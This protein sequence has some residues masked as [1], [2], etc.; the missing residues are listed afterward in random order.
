M[1]LFSSLTGILLSLILLV[2][3]VRKYTSTIYLGVFF[4]LVSL[5]GLVVYAQLYSGSVYLVSIF[6]YNINF[7]CYLIGPML[8]WYIRS[9]LTDHSGL[10]KRDLWHIVPMLLVLAATL[11][12]LLTSYAEK[13]EIA[14]KIVED[15]NF[16]RTYKASFIFEIAPVWVIYITRPLHIIVYALW[17][18][19]I[20]GRYLKRRRELLVLSRQYFMVRWIPFLLVFLVLGVVCHVLVLTEAFVHNGSNIM[21]SLHALQILALTGL[22]GLLVSPFFFPRILYGLPQLPEAMMVMKPVNGS[23]VENILKEPEPTPEARPTPHYEKYYMS[24]IEQKTET[25]MKDLQPFLESDFNMMQLS[26]LIKVPAH[27]IA[28]YFREVKRQSFNEYRNEWR[29]NYAKDLIRE[30]KAAQLTLEAIGFSSG[31]SSRNAFFTAFKRYEGI[32]PG[33]FANAVN[34]FSI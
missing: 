1:L 20:F 3:N 6:Y 26:V 21:Y 13:V 30:G 5:Y 9:V 17:S 22:T 19:T 32:S 14:E 31:F 7:L 12:H 16:L 18:A 33:A 23:D 28:Y 10:F 25:C 27:H 8:Y 29:I 24:S 34:E 4:F 15:A 2:F 11:P